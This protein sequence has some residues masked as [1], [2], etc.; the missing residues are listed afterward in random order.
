VVTS[1]AVLVFFHIP[2]VVCRS[3]QSEKKQKTSQCRA[4]EVLHYLKPIKCGGGG[5]MTQRNNATPHDDAVNTPYYSRFD[6][7]PDFSLY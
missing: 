3:S 4:Q 2:I 1:A 7:K 6:A 5:G